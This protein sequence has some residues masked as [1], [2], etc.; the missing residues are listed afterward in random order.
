VSAFLPWAAD[1]VD[2][3]ESAGSVALSACN[4]AE[5]TFAL[6]LL[7]LE[8]RHRHGSL[9]RLQSPTANARTVLE[10]AKA[11]PGA[12]VIPALS[13][14]LA[15]S[16][17]ELGHEVRG[18][19]A[20]LQADGRRVTARPDWRKSSATCSAQGLCAG[21]GVRSRMHPSQSTGEAA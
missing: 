21:R 4:D 6:A 11:A 1:T 14:S 2:L 10:I 20:T 13:L 18:L 7:S 9:G 17:Y 5:R 3:L 19:L 15:T 8:A 12:L 16:P